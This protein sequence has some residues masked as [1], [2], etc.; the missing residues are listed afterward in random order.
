MKTAMLIFR[1]GSAEPERRELDLPKD[2]G[3]QR[4]KDLI[5]PLLRAE[6]G[7]RDIFSDIER[8]AVLYAGKPCDMFVAGNGR[9]SFLPR[10]EWL[11]R[12]EAATAI[13]RAAN[14]AG[15]T[16]MPKAADPEELHS[17]AGT[18]ILF[19]RPVWF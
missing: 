18:A 5:E 14:Q 8:V 10:E 2:P 13:Y 16:A 9:A 12:N 4:L 19:D 1:V 6:H 15:R 11:P 17:I 3:Y 7:G